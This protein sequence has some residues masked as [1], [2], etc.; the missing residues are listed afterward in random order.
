M[1]NATS[2]RRSLISDCVGILTIG[3]QLYL[4]VRWLVP[5][6]GSRIILGVLTYIVLAGIALYLWHKE[7]P[8]KNLFEPSEWATAIVGSVVMG[9]VSFGIDMLIGLFDNPKLSPI[10]A[11]TKAGSPFGFPLT[12]ML[13]PGFTM[14][15][16]AGLL[17]ALMLRS[18]PAPTRQS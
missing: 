5:N 16:I 12:V 11:G 9:G 18:G 3:V 4:L 6:D 1:Q 10:E 15:A 8:V 14:L 13:C 7:P 2:N 17:H